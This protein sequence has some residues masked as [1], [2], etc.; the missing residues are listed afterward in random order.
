MRMF[1][2]VLIAA[3]MAAT[4]SGGAA[5]A[6]EGTT[7]GADTAAPAP[8]DKTRY[9]LKS[10]AVTGTMLQRQSCKTL[11]QWK[12]LGIDLTQKKH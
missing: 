11:A 7:P 6:K 8:S 12:A 5:V 4:V 9:C 3:A 2:Q 1:K 10:E